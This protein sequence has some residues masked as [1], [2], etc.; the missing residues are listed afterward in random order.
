MCEGQPVNVIDPF[1]GLRVET[2]SA[3]LALSDV[4]TPDGSGSGDGLSNP[5]SDT[6][7]VV[8]RVTF[9]TSATTAIVISPPE[10]VDTDGD[11]IPDYQEGAGD[12][13][14]DTV[15]N[16]QDLD[17][18]GDGTNDILDNCP[19]VANPG[20]GPAPFGQTVQAANTARF[21]WPI[22]VSF[23]AAHGG[24]TTSGD[25]GTFTVDGT[26]TGFGRDL[27]VPDSLAAGTGIWYLLKP[28]CVAGSWISG[29]ISEFPGRDST[30]P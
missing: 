19:L 28:D 4:S 6:G 12:V 20:Q 8:T 13:D 15:A 18:D 21:E 22:A 25:I 9:S 11:G 1:T 26:Y 5:F 30:L 7:Q 27:P 24:F 14:D 10:P 29:G 17:S 3:M 2:P 16:F 23:V